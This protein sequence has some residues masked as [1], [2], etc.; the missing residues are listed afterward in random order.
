MV[1]AVKESSLGFG[2]QS[3]AVDG[4]AISQSMTQIPGLFSTPSSTNVI[5]ASAG[6]KRRHGVLADSGPQSNCEFLT[7]LLSRHIL[8]CTF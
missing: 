6:S 7:E 3:G 8:N 5:N 2:A 4:V 1:H